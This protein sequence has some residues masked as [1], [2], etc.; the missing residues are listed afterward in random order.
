MP[1]ELSAVFRALAEDTD[2]AAGNIASA[3]AR[4]TETTADTEDGNVA[5]TLAADAESARAIAVIGRDPV[6]L[7]DGTGRAGT[8]WAGAGHV[9]ASSPEAEAAYAAIRANTGDVPA[10]AANTGI[11]QDIIA[12]VKNHLFLT[13]HDVP[14][15]PGEVAH[16]YFTADEEIA[17]LWGKAEDGTLNPAQQGRFRSLISHEYV[18]G[19]LMESG[20]PYRS[21]APEAWNGDEQTFNPPYFGAHEVAPIAATGSLRQWTVLGL[22]PPAAPI[23]P[24]LSNLEDVVNA[25][26]KGLKL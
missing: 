11:S 5:R 3:M 25:A 24:N 26:R 8:G 19:R 23:A 2:R 18:E 17:G 12:Q 22:T 4:F 13:E 6:T 7:A 16:G 15:G 20:M 14:I 1:G 9:E 21:A 10:I